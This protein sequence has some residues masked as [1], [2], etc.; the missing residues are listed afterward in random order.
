MRLPV[1]ACVVM[2]S[3]AVASA[4][5]TAVDPMTAMPSPPPGKLVVGVLPGNGTFA[6]FVMKTS[7]GAWGGIAVDLWKEIAR[8]LKL[9]YEIREMTIAEIHDPAKLGQ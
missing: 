5:P 7:D 4:Q 1:C 6:P 8:R 2:F 9:D 3:V